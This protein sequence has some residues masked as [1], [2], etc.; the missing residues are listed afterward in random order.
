MKKYLLGIDNGGSVAKCAVFDLNGNELAVASKRIPIIEP[1]A[2]WIERDM[3]LIWKGNAEI[4]REAVSKAHIVPEEILGIGLTGYGN[5]ICLVDKEGKQTYNAIVSSDNRAAELC[6]RL[7]Q[8][9]VQNKIYSLTYQEFWSA[10]TAVL[11]K[12]FKENK[13]EILEKTSCVLSI[14]DFIRMKLTGEYCY[15][16]TEATCCGLMNVHTQQFDP[17]IFEALQLSDCIDKMPV[18]T[19]ITGISGLLTSKAAAETGL[20]PGIPVAGSCYDVNACA[21]A[22]GVLDEDTLCMIAGTWSINELLTKTLIEGANSIALSYLPGYYI[23]EESSPTSTGNLD[24]F[25]ETFLRPDRPEASKEELYKECDDMVSS[26]S[27]EE[28]SVIFVPYI[29]ASATH[30]DAQG[31]FFNLT[32]FNNRR[33]IIRAVY[34]GVVFSSMLHVK[35]LMEEGKT[36]SKAILSGGITKSELWSQMVCDAFQIPLDVSSASEPGALGAAICAAISGGAYADYEEAVE[37]MVHRK[38]TYFPDK[39]KKDIY[40]R[41]FEAYEKALSSLDAFYT[42]E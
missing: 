16:L 25:I 39:S 23:M 35:R 10:Q 34:E 13:L 11:L 17:E 7:S 14:K 12:W 28:S 20:I 4:I 42:V 31:A 5:G 21:L 40:F 30:P 1:C 41:K 24:W 6:Q 19:D 38:K 9:G 2:G 3:D 22:S 27:P 33:H 8:E 36:F 29:F 37:K 15:E 18:F 32:S 26:I